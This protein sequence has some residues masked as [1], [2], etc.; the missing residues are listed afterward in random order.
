MFCYSCEKAVPTELSMYHEREKVGGV[1]CA[2]C[3]DVNFGTA[4]H[5]IAYTS[6]TSTTGTSALTRVTGEKLLRRADQ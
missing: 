5:A 3:T 6:S 4:N 1:V 2:A